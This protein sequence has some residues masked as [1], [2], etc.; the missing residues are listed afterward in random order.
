MLYVRYEGVKKKTRR[1]KKTGVNEKMGSNRINKWS[2]IISAVWGNMKTF[3]LIKGWRKTK[4]SFKTPFKRSWSRI[5]VFSVCSTYVEH[6]KWT[7]LLRVHIR[8]WGRGAGLGDLWQSSRSE[9]HFG[10]KPFSALWNDWSVRRIKIWK[11]E[12]WST[13]LNSGWAAVLEPT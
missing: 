11:L 7:L 12:W 4:E 10:P 5:Q 8:L 1:C 13:F 3:S 9:M 6:K 2:C